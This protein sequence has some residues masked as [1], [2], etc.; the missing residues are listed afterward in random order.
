MADYRWAL[1]A[2]VL[3]LGLTVVG[4]LRRNRNGT[5]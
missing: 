2:F 4:I 1:D 3:I 5:K